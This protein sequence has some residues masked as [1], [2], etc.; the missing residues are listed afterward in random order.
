MVLSL[1]YRSMSHNLEACIIRGM[2]KV[3]LITGGSDGLGRA[4]A[5]RLSSS[6]VVVI[7]SNNGPK[8]LKAAAELGLTCVVGDV[9]DYSEVEAAI[10]QA[11]ERHGGLDVV[12][13]CAGLWIEGELETNDPGDIRRVLEVNTLG[14]INVSR[15]VIPRLVARGGGRIINIISQAGLNAKAGRSVY[16]ASKFALT[17]FTRSL[18]DELAVQGI[19][20]TGIYPGKLSTGMFS[21]M[22]INKSMDDALDPDE[23]ARAVEMMVLAA[24]TT[25]FTEIG[26]RSIKAKH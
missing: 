1:F 2:K 6:C 17:G 16:N 4:I 7:M 18:A 22:G 5:K 23:V 14:T 3:V 9:S 8:C 21:K 15:A 12:I 24:P 19:G 26:M 13:N 11:I 25:Q 10:A 20:V